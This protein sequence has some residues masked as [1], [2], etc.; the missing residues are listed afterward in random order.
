MTLRGAGADGGGGIAASLFG[1]AGCRVAGVPARV[2][3]GDS[4]WRQL[5]GTRGATPG[6]ER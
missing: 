2:V 1:G 3:S 4:G 5:S 6:A